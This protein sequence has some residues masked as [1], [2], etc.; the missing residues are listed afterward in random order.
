[1]KKVINREHIEG[2]VYDHNL[3]LKTVQ[4]TESKNFGKEFI[5]GTLDIQTDDEGCNI[6]TVNFTYVTEMTAKGTK[7][8][9][10]AVLKNIIEGAKTVLSDGRDAAMMVRVDTALALNDFYTTRNGEEELV[11][12][13]RNEGGFVSQ[14][15]KLNPTDRSTFEFDM[16]INGTRF[17]DENEET[18]APEYLVVKGAVFNFRNAMLPVELVVK[19]KS[20]IDYF[21]SLEASASNLVFTR[22]KGNITSQVTSVKREEESAFG[23]P[24]VRE[25]T[26]TVREWVIT[27]AASEP[28][29]IGDETNGITVDEI[30]KALADREVYLADVKKRQDEYQATKNATHAAAPSAG[31][32]AAAGA[33]NF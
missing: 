33:F 31:T 18:G 16:L 21:S 8:A 28:Y 17:V 30:K 14:I 26:R 12:A 7:N 29:E 6:V 23:E 3:A 9:T 32:T 5:G 15:N 25:Y 2:W 1:M 4:N 22:V 10:F 24:S 27:W 20:G 19:S 11:Q 13:K